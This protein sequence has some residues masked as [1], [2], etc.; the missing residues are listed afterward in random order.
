MVVPYVLHSGYILWRSVLER[1][2]P[3]PAEPLA[4]AREAQN[5]DFTPVPSLALPAL[6]ILTGHARIEAVYNT[7]LKRMERLARQLSTARSVPSSVSFAQAPPATRPFSPADL[8]LTTCHF[9]ER[10]DK[11]P[12]LPAPPSFEAAF[13]P[14]ESMFHTVF[15]RRY[16]YERLDDAKQNAL[17]HLWKRWRSDMSLLEQTAAYVVQ[18]AI[19]GASPHRKI[20]REQRIQEHELPMLEYERYIDIR[21]TDQAVILPGCSGLIAAWTCRLLLPRLRKRF[22]SSRTPT[23]CSPFSMT[24]SMSGRA[25]QDG[26]A[27][28]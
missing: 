13:S 3:V 19:W 10:L 26:S 21:V 17:L 2:G 25:K 27:R 7:A 28:A 22:V 14:Y 9:L 16:P 15:Y 1:L 12:L 8:L 4:E 5:V 18:A 11:P 20:E 23:R 6:E 24:S